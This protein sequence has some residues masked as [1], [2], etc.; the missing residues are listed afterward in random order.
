MTDFLQLPSLKTITV[1]D[2]GDY[3]Q[4][5]A[6]SSTSVRPICPHCGAENPYG[7]GTINPSFIDTPTHGKK[8]LIDIERKRYRCR[9]CAKTFVES[10]ADLD[11]N[12]AATKRLVVYIKQRVF[13]D[14]FSKV[15][16]EVGLDEKT[17]RNIFAV[18]AEQMGK[19]Y[20]FETPRVLGI[21]ELGLLGTAR[22]II[23]NIET[24]TI[25]DL[26]PARTKE[27]ITPYLLSLKNQ[28]NIEV[29]TMD[30]WKQY[31][32]VVQ[33]IFPKAAIVVDKFH[34][35]KNLMDCFDDARKTI[36]RS[37]LSKQRRRLVHDETLLRMRTFDLSPE[38]MEIVQ[39]WCNEFGELGHAYAAKESFMQITDQYLTKDE[40]RRAIVD[41][42]KCLDPTVKVFFD[43]F[44]TSI[45]N[46][47]EG[48]LNGFEHRYTNAYTESLN[49]LVKDKVRIGRGYSFEV[50][51][52]LMVYDQDA[53]K[54]GST[55]LKQ[56]VKREA[57]NMNFST[58]SRI[59]CDAPREYEIVEEVVTKYYGA[60]ISTLCDKLEAGIFE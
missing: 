25:C 21:D 55:S 34:I 13:K 39:S 53:I 38:Q 44:L 41:W 12:N 57:L 56:R 51:R 35:S 19:K 26:L 32:E 11:E 4:V 36:K 20:Q 31:K 2:N 42:L 5:N 45:A 18:H 28:N 49:R 24:Q 23:T 8:V 15:A 6:V 58:T 16:R 14:T 60:K 40:A 10:I 33:T 59:M 9:S 30:M 47:Q 3:Y 1:D 22:G 46:W 7:H 52:A 54:A 27:V 37:L 17:V 29:V 50:I 43:P 48:I